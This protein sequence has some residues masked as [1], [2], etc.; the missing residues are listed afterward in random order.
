MEKEKY[1]GK[2]TRQVNSQDIEFAD[3]KEFEVPSAVAE[4]NG[5][6]YHA[7][8]SFS[9]TTGEYQTFYLPNGVVRVCYDE[10]LVREEIPDVRVR[11]YKNGEIDYDRDAKNPDAKKERVIKN[12]ALAKFKAVLKAGQSQGE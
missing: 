4:R 5:R 8:G 1:N 10:D 6:T 2:F 11:E 12:K 9:I 7:D 3:P